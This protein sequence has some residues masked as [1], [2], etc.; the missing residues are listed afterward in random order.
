MG[1]FGTKVE[2]SLK[3]K[4]KHGKQID[5]KCSAFVPESSCMS[6]TTEIQ[7]K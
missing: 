6:K 1:E 4:I 3:L 2:E 5:V 7:F